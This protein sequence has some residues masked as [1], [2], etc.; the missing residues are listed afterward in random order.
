MKRNDNAYAAEILPAA[1]MLIVLIVAIFWFVVPMMNLVDQLNDKQDYHAIDRFDKTPI[2]SLESGQSI[3]GYFVLGSGSVNGRDVY[4]YYTKNIDDGYV[5]NHV[6][7]DMTVIYMDENASPYLISKY[8][9]TNRLHVQF[10]HSYEL[11]VP[12]GMITKTFSVMQ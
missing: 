1:M 2:E 6:D 10:I 8:V 3:H 4:I 12:N 9:E 5:R 7:A 11:H